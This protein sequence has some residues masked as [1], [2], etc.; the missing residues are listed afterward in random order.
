MKQDSRTPEDPTIPLSIRDWWKEIVTLSV[1]LAIVINVGFRVV[2]K[3]LN[4]VTEAVLLPDIPDAVEEGTEEIECTVKIKERSKTSISIA[5]ETGELT[6]ESSSSEYNSRYISDFDHLQCLGKGGFGVVF[7]AKKKIDDCEYAIKRIYLPQCDEAK[8][9]MMR[10]VKALAALEHPGIVRYFH[11]WWESPPP[12]WQKKTDNSQLLQGVPDGYS[13]ALSRDWML[14]IHSVFED[15]EESAS[16]RCDNDECPRR[17]P[18]K[19]TS[20]SDDPLGKRY[21]FDTGIENLISDH[22]GFDLLRHNDV[23]YEDDDESFMH[24]SKDSEA[25]EDDSFIV[26]EQ[27]TAEQETNMD[28]ANS[29]GTSDYG[30][31]NKRTKTLVADDSDATESNDDNLKEKT[32]KR[33]VGKCCT[34]KSSCLTE[35]PLFL[36][37]QMQLCKRETLKDWLSERTSV[38]SLSRSFSIF[39]QIVNAVEYFHGQGMMHRDLK[40]ANIFFSLDDSVKVGDFGLVTAITRPSKGKHKGKSF[41]DENHTGQVGTQ[42]YMSPEQATG[43]PYNH[44]VDIYSLGLILFELL[45]RFSTQMERMQLIYRLKHGT[46]PNDM[47][48]TNQGK[49]VKM[50]TAENPDDRPEA[51]DIKGFDFLRNIEAEIA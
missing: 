20:L 24:V 13:Y 39:M 12:G 30:N 1:I 41:H 45:S 5:T 15:E 38:I 47:V 44:K 23:F 27:E 33:L 34:R 43:R 22:G 48:D 25:T 35:A 49:L 51:K 42:L 28:S 7:K 17:S 29:V 16:S 4:N 14:E 32:K 11:A 37:I 26:F 40:P 9:K 2:K 6:G 8:E 46:L 19:K 18:R 10:E 50:L 31:N 21:N 3:K 36:Y